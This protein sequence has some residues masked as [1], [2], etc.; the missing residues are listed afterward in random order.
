MLHE[1]QPISE[2]II[3]V[4]NNI[5]AKSFK[6]RTIKRLVNT[7]NKILT[8]KGSSKDISEV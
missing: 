6:A 3:I 7:R 1:P 2:L 5:R 8:T 4:L